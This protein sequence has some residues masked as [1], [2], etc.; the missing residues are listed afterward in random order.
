MTWDFLGYCIAQGRVH[1][2]VLCLQH[3]I[4]VFRSTPNVAMWFTTCFSH[5]LYVPGFACCT[6]YV[7]YFTHLYPWPT[8]ISSVQSLSH[9]RLSATPRTAATK[10]P[11]LS[12]TP[13][14]HPNPRPSSQWCHPTI[15]SSVVPFS[16]CPQ[17]FP[18]SVSFLMSRLFESGGQS[19]EALALALALPMNIQ[20]DFLE[21]RFITY[22]SVECTV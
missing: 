12:P 21:I 3:L 1:C 18:A 2:S 13:S 10:P 8:F 6:L 4:S 14:I 7:L 22:L 11:C 16:S 19:T 17:S 9:V 20:V 5:S 15:S